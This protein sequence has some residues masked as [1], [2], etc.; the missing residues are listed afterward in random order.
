MGITER[1]MDEKP[2]TVEL[3]KQQTKLKMIIDKNFLVKGL[4]TEIW[5]AH[6]RNEE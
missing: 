3:E 1:K 5:E 2:Y 4:K 6:C